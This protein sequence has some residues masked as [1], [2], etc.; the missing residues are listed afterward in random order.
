[1]KLYYLLFLVC[2]HVR[3]FA[4]PPPNNAIALSL[5]G[6]SATYLNAFGIENNVGGLAFSPQ[7]ISLNAS[8]R[9]G[10][11]EYSNIMLAGNFKSK[12]A[13]M[14][15]SYQISPI[16]GLT[17]QK[18]QLGISKKMGN[19]VAVGV[20]LNYHRFSSTNAY[21]HTS[22]FL[23]F[24]AGLYYKINKK[25][26]VGFQIFNPNRSTVTSFPFEKTSSLFRV[27]IDYQFAENIT[28]YSDVLQATHEKLDLNV[29]LELQK[30][31]YTLRGGF[32]LKQLIAIGFG[33]QTKM[34]NIDVTA[35][36]HNQLGFSPSLNLVYAF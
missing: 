20:A 33:W 12:F 18:A 8:N 25:L 29:G 21:Y 36:Y 23:T 4:I 35:A 15:F 32:G 14:G 34:L 6:A 24:N 19:N 16:A 30:D 5:G 3:L 9:F 31:Q 2:L 26:N 27:G 7:Q 22:K 10:L 17:T 1:M 28:C 13:S 11:S